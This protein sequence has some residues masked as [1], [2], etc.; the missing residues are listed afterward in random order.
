V[1]HWT[2]RVGIAKRV[3]LPP[4]VTIV[5][6]VGVLP[7][8]ISAFASLFRKYRMEG[9]IL[10]ERLTNPLVS[11]ARLVSGGAAE[12]PSY[13]ANPPEP[14]ESTTWGK[15]QVLQD[16][17]RAELP[18]E[19]LVPVFE[20]Y[21]NSA[22]IPQ[23]ADF[24]TYTFAAGTTTPLYPEMDVG[25]SD[26]DL[27][28]WLDTPDA[29]VEFAATGASY[30]YSYS[31]P[32]NPIK[33]RDL[34]DFSD[35]NAR[36]SISLMQIPKGL[37]NKNGMDARFGLD[38]GP[39]PELAMPL[40]IM[41][42][43]FLTYMDAKLRVFYAAESINGNITTVQFGTFFKDHISTYPGFPVMWT[44][45][46]KKVETLKKGKLPRA[47]WAVD[48]FS[49]IIDC[50]IYT[51]TVDMH[52]N[53]YDGGFSHNFHAT[54]GGFNHFVSRVITHFKRELN[55]YPDLLKTFLRVTKNGNLDQAIF[56]TL[57]TSDQDVKKV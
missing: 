51:Q 42:M 11:H 17:A 38:S 36:Q 41:I 34:P 43:D 1:V 2:L 9:N 19:Y 40:I 8:V 56:S 3:D 49:I 33:A 54:G 28:A 47:V 30:I 44:S 45:I 4:L 13:G 15:D 10:K 50:I 26:D 52:K 5:S 37:T 23:G 7:T 20:E 57:M 24:S 6:T 14:S 27:L 29:A 31:A 46:F 35:P 48:L 55:K 25:D 22:E 53:Y 32:G 21:I 39:K 12:I 16:I 18:K